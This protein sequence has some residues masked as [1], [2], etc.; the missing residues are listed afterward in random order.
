MVRLPARGRTHGFGDGLAV[1]AGKQHHRMRDLQRA[2]A[3]LQIVIEDVHALFLFAQ[4]RH[5]FEHG[6]ESLLR[7]PLM[8]AKN[9]VFD[10]QNI[11]EMHIAHHH[12]V[13]IELFVAAQNVA[14]KAD[15]FPEKRHVRHTLC[16]KSLHVARLTQTHRG[17]VHGHHVGGGVKDL[18]VNGAA[19]IP[20]AIDM[21]PPNGIVRPIDCKASNCGPIAS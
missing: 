16:R 8:L 13:A 9:A 15:G 1:G 2:I 10:A 3:L 19:L 18:I 21:V 6:T 7:G 11:R 14:D 20:F 12:V 4:K 17:I 5:E